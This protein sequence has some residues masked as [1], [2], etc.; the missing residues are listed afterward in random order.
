MLEMLEGIEEYNNAG[1]LLGIEG[2]DSN[3]ELLGCITKDE[4][5]CPPTYHQ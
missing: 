4:S 2:L 3:D 1:A 5:Y